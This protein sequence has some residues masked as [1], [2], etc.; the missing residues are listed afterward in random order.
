MS[1]SPVSEEQ[2][3]AAINP[4]SVYRRNLKSL[5]ELMSQGGSLSGREANCAFLNTQGKRFA[6]IASIIGF[7]FTDDARGMAVCDWDGDG[8]LDIWTSNRTAP[9]VRF[10]S[11]QTPTQ[12]HFISLRLKGVKCNRDAIGATVR[13]QLGEKPL[14]KTLRAGEG[15]LSQSSKWLHFGL[16]D[17]ETPIDV[18]VRWPGGETQMFT[19]L[20]PDQRYHL[21]QGESSAIADHRQERQLKIQ[22]T[23]QPVPSETPRARILLSNPIPATRL[24]YRQFDGKTR[25]IDPAVQGPL[26][27]NLWSTTCLPCLAELEELTQNAEAIRAAKINILVLAT[28]GAAPRSGKRPASQKILQ[29]LKFPFDAGLATDELFTR[30]GL[31]RDLN[32]NVKADIPVPT[33]L[34]FN[35]AGQLAAIYHGPVDSQQI[36]AD[37]QHLAD[38][39]S[40]W[41]AYAARFTGK[42][43]RSPSNRASLD[44]PRDLLTRGFTEDVLAFTQT[45]LET[46]KT[47]SDFSKI[48][49]WLGD[50]LIEDGKLKDGLDQYRQALQVNP[51]DLIAL[52]NFAWQ[53]ATNPRDDIRNGQ[54]AVK[55]AT[56]AAKLTQNNNPGLLDTLAAS[57]AEAGD[58]SQAIGV[59]KRAIEIAE[60]SGNL[61]LSGRLRSRLTL[62]GRGEPYRS[63]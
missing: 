39:P 33:S 2:F 5:N 54:M 46:L 23:D 6:N 10:L 36:L 11:N 26:L 63:L 29:E 34:L 44:L 56:H 25:I 12:H 19:K 24:P 61:P 42:W 48:L 62:Y 57:L 35:Q 1:R 53:L 52:N 14:L 49:V 7:D 60:R 58:F 3:S 20:Q 4:E 16:G 45:H 37:V 59:S 22:A 47:H 9:R 40:D 32:F 38:S 13:I 30:V 50:Q 31:I 21:I 17:N 8:D 41:K 43:N 27:V 28:D 18:E 55:M 15:F 51:N